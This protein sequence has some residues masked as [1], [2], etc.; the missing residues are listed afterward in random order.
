MI[1]SYQPSAIS[2]QLSKRD[3]QKD[4]KQEAARKLSAVS[5]QQSARIRTERVLDIRYQQSEIS[6]ERLTAD[7][8]RLSQM[9]IHRIR[10]INRRPTP[11]YAD[12]KSTKWIV[13]RF[14]T[15]LWSAFRS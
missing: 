7:A 4:R 12:Q 14:N 8:R 3:K 2:N 10:V 5:Y 15:K 13:Q 9:I 1:I 11:T 6:R